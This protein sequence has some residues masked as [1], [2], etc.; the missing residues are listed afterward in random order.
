MIIRRL[1]T[2]DTTTLQSLNALFADVFQDPKSYAEH[3][4]DH[5]YLTDFLSDE[6]HIVIV[7]E[8][9]GRVV[10]GLVAY[11]L[12]K[13]E[14]QRREVFVY[15]VAVAADRQRQGIGKQLMDAVKVEAKKLGA[16]A[17]FLQA[18]EGDAAIHFYES[19][20]PSENLKT[21]NFDFLV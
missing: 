14:Q 6:K 21:R 19:L 11:F 15:D 20:K 2:D 18:D 5:N 12:D 9:D 10:G 4:P 8:V 1:T 16:Y 13:F 3:K 7:A 17:V